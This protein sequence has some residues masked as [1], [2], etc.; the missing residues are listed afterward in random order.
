MYFNGK[1]VSA[2]HQS[3]SYFSDPSSGL[4]PHLFEGMHMRAWVRNSVLRMLFDHLS[5][6]Y[7]DPHSWVKAWI[8]G[9]GVSYQWSAERDPGDLD[10][11]VG[12]DYG[13]FRRLN[14]DYTGMT[15]EEI[16]KMFNDGFNRDLLPKT[17]DWEGYELTYYVNTMSNIVDINPYAA[18]DLIND[19]WTVEPVKNPSIPHSRIWEEMVRKDHDRGLDLIKN[20]TQSLA[21]YKGSVANGPRHR[22]AEIRLKAAIDQASDFYEEMHRNRSTAFSP[23]GAGYADFNNYRWQAGKESGIIPALKQIK[24]YR[25]DSKDKEDLNTYGVE[26]PDADLLT[27]RALAYRG[28]RR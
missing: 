27:R 6:I 18:Y 3:T 25:D 23:T 7:Q 8:A 16:A 21:D 20:Y 28:V 17:S 5:V 19:S 4:D 10:C 26:L 9:S 2:E 15:D 13:T 22:N 12:I 14:Q 11:L 1:P 24:Q